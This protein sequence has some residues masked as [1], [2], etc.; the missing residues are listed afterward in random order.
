MVEINNENFIVDPT[1][2][3]PSEIK[4]KLEAYVDSLP[5][6]EAW[7]P[8]FQNSVGNTILNLLTG[9]S[10][11]LSYQ[12]TLGRREAYGPY[13]Q[14][15]SSQ[16][17][18]S[19]ALGYSVFRGRNSQATL[20]I[21]PNFTGVI[22]KYTVVGTVK[23]V[24]L[25]ALNDTPVT[26]GV[27]TTIK[28]VVGNLN[29]STITIDTTSL[30]IFRFKDPKVT[31]DYILKLNNVEVTTSDRVLDLENEK[32]VVVTNVYDAVDVMYLNSD[33]FTL[34]YAIGDELQLT[35]VIRKDLEYTTADFK[36][37]YGDIT[38]IVIDQLYQ[39]VESNDSIRINAPLFHETQKVLRGR[40]DYKKLVK[41]LDTSI[42]DTSQRDISPALVEV[43]YVRELTNL[44][45]EAEKLTLQAALLKSIGMGVAPPVIS[46]PKK[47]PLKLTITFTLNNSTTDP[48]TYVDGVLSA[49]Q[50]T[51]NLQL[52]FLV[53]ENLLEAASFVQT[54]RLNISGA[55][56]TQLT[57]YENNQYVL[58]TV[59]NGFVYYLSRIIR[60]TYAVEPT[61]PTTV[62]ATITDG[63]LVWETYTTDLSANIFTW[64]SQTEKFIGD[65]VAPTLPNGF[66]YKVVSYVNR[67]FGNNEVQSLT[68]S[69]TPT[70]GTYRVYADDE[71]TV[72][73]PYNA[74]A[75]ELQTALNALAQFT[76]LEVIGDYTTSFTIQFGGSDG[77]KEQPLLASTDPGI[78][79]TQLITFSDIP[80]A[81]NWSLDFLGEVTGL[82]NFNA[83]ASDVKTALELLATVSLVTVTGDYNNGFNVTFQ[84][85]EAKQPNPLLI[86]ASISS[87]GVNAR[88]TVTFSSVPSSGAWR[89][90][91]PNTGS[92]TND[93]AF[94]ANNT[95]IQSEL[96]L[97]DEFSNIVVSGDYST[98]LIFD[99]TVNDGKKPQPLLDVNNS[100]VNAEQLVLF[101]T[102]PD[103]GSWVLTYDGQTT[104][105]LPHNASLAVIEAALTN[106]SN[107]TAVTVTGDYVNGIN[108]EFIGV[109]GLQPKNL[110]GVDWV[111]IDE[112]QNLSFSA[113][114]LGGE[115]FTLD[116]DGQTTVSILDTDGAS[117]LTTK[118]QALS[119]IGVGNVAV[120]GSYGSGF[121]ITFQGDLASTNVAQIVVSTNSTSSTITP[122]TT[123]AG[124]SSSPNLK[125]LGE[126]V[127]V[128]TQHNVLGLIPGNSLGGGVTITNTETV[129][130]SLPVSNLTRNGS[131][132]TVGISHN[133]VGQY[134]ANNT[135]TTMTY[136]KIV[137][138]TAVEP[139]WPTTLGG[140]VKDGQ[141]LWLA[142]EKE[143]DPPIWEPYIDYPTG[144]LI[145]PT[146]TVLDSETSTELVFQ[147]IGHLGTSKVTEPTWPTVLGSEV[148]DGDVVWVAAS[149]TAN[150]NQ[151]SEDEYYVIE[152][153]VIST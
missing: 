95:T 82:L 126:A 122:T 21:T 102:V 148:V 48:V 130:G 79:N 33:D 84:G 78:D 115:T 57:A 2:V 44:F 138:A 18:L 101:S 61:W 13:A 58:P 118:L 123:I 142:V 16:V 107:L 83:S 63:N 69:P 41:Q 65:V 32:F 11:F 73:L 117:E 38:G 121:D 93:L 108:V 52:D 66:M 143:T 24:N 10:S 56:W 51:L 1:T 62:G 71:A 59:P 34:K 6:G 43:F 67:S 125:R 60:K 3:S 120:T 140:E 54:A 15:Y 149:P 89:I 86:Q 47:C 147:C 94:N 131:S 76:S 99:F 116:F 111:G 50:R 70:S 19:Q 29:T 8:F 31:E 97:F 37:T 26:N 20:T 30:K 55:T 85:S 113:P 75:I 144:T 14:L 36:F 146:T 127:V 74:T 5:D 152:A 124:R 90:H 42:V 100:G 141:I 80:N 106:L 22:N 45:T 153:E 105:D 39:G 98:G 88:Q 28:V 133:P 17:A 77:N 134:P 49:F 23:N 35:Y 27:S 114:P 87:P 72:D 53:L 81:G 150:P 151:L 110:L 46:D 96:N 119:N 40:E 4:K 145:S 25:I 137:D 92:Y 136:T 109:D 64:T 103:S 139:T 68:F 91:N 132:V 112:V 9:I 7:T 128:T 129:T 135:G 104:I 12:I